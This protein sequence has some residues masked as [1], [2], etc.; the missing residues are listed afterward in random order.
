MHELRP[1]KWIEDVHADPDLPGVWFIDLSPGDVA[2]VAFQHPSRDRARKRARRG[3]PPADEATTD[4]TVE[5]RLS[6]LEAK[7]ETLT[8]LLEEMTR[9]PPGAN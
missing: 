6:V 5:Q 8:R 4:L 7:L 3:P 1:A 2:K 9:E